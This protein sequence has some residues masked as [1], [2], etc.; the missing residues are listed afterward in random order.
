MRKHR[1]TTD[2]ASP[3]FGKSAFTLIELLVVIAILG[4]LAALLLAGVSQ[5]KDRARNLQCLHNVRQIAMGYKGAVDGDGEG[6][7]G[8]DAVADWIA[9]HAGLPE[10]A[11]ICPNAP[12]RS[13][14][15]SRLLAGALTRGSVNSAWT[16][17]DWPQYWWVKRRRVSFPT[18][19]SGSYLFNFWLVGREAVEDFQGWSFVGLT[20]FFESDERVQPVLTPVVGDGTATFGLPKATDSPPVSLFYGN[21]ND[22]NTR[23]WMSFLAIPRHGKRPSKAPVTWPSDKPM[24]GTINVAFYDG[25]AE[26]VPLDKLWQLYWHANF[27]PPAKRPGLP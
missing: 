19:R 13:T 20:N 2:Q 12:V 16:W 10:E 5:A 21:G 9:D 3:L 4:V 15:D 25:H 27:Q 23:G 6:R 22:P 26:A 24:P 8:A 7:L 11:W 1:I 14:T 18:V 17:S